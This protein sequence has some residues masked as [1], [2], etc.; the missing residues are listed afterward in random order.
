MKTYPNQKIIQKIHKQ[1]CSPTNLYARFNLNALNNAACNLDS[2]AFKLWV[3]I[4]KNK[5]TD[6]FK[7]ALSNKRIEI[8]FG[9]KKKQ[10]D[11]AIHTLIDKGY[12][13]C[14]NG[15]N[16]EFF[17]EP[18]AEDTEKEKRSLLQ[19]VTNEPST[20]TLQENINKQSNITID[21]FIF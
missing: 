11:N 5:D 19:K 4:A 18:S 2:G 8:E 21:E 6:K 9:M 14:I 1:P 10:Y 12:L 20:K 17:E 15:T 16:Y 3:Y 13:V 7:L